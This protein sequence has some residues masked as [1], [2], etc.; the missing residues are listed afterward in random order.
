MKRRRR[1]FVELRP[2]E[3]EPP[4]FAQP[5]GLFLGRFDAEALRREL[6]EAGVFEGLAARG[7]SGVSLA[8]TVDDGE[9]AVR[10]LAESGGAPLV[11]LRLAEVSLVAADDL[12]RRL[13]LDILSFLFIRWVALQ[14]PR[15][16]FTV[17]RPR[18]PGQRYPGLGVGR[19]LYERLRAWATAWGKDG[20]LNVPEYLHNAVFYSE[21]FR[22][23]SAVRQ[24]RFE[25]L[26]RDLLS[27][28]VAA[29]STAVAEG[30]VA[31]QRS[32][33]PIRWEP[34]EMVAALTDRLRG[35][36]ESDGYREAAAAAARAV[37]FRL[38]R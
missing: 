6:A 32:A 25:A 8:T 18:L 2:A 16:E 11:D 31:E 3:M 15:R 29:A 17:E 37:R 27:L 14:D 26:W 10:L 22:F 4:R 23:L 20:L 21:S 5:S 36:L 34:A 13:G 24:G 38:R 7:Y 30:R 9:H 1:A 12:M 19:R 35:Y 33:R 28:G